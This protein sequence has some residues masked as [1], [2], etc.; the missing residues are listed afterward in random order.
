MP[1]SVDDGVNEIQPLSQNKV[2]DNF[3]DD[4]LDFSEGNPFGDIS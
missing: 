1:I 3:A 4:F 2:F